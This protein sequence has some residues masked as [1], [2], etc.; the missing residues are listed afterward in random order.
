MECKDVYS[1]FDAGGS[2]LDNVEIEANTTKDAITKYLKGGKTKRCRAED[3]IYCV[4]RLRYENG[5]CY[6]MGNRVWYK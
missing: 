6:K 4:T 1:I 2:L 5:F 3:A